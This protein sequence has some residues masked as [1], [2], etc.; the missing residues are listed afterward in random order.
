MGRN[1][2]PQEHN[3]QISARA[4]ER[5]LEGIYFNPDFSLHISRI[6]KE[7]GKEAQCNRSGGIDLL[8]QDSQA[9]PGCQG[10][11][12]HLPLSTAVTTTMTAVVTNSP[13]PLLYSICSWIHMV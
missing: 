8:C 9:T 2:C 10:S 12:W 7:L 5:H 11:H 3:C 6:C 4:E 1:W 13:L